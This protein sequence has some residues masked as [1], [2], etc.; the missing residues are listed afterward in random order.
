MINTT[1]TGGEA[2]VSGGNICKF[3]SGSVDVL[4]GATISGGTVYS[5]YIILESAGK[6]ADGDFEFEYN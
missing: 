5:D 1:V 4:A 3:N 2:A 6:C